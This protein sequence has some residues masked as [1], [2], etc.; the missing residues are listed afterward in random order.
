MPSRSATGRFLAPLADAISAAIGNRVATERP[1][2][3]VAMVRGCGRFLVEAGGTNDRMVITR[4]RDAIA[5]SLVMVGL[6][7]P[8]GGFDGP[9]RH[10]DK[11]DQA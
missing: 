8:A 7:A 2:A 5:T 4:R 9:H 10:S 11:E 1:D 3:F 6:G